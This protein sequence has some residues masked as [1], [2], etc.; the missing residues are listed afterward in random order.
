MKQFYV[1]LIKPGEEGG[2][3]GQIYSGRFKEKNK[4]KWKSMKYP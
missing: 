3:M 2:H 4:W 1:H